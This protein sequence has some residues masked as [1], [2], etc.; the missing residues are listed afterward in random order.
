MEDILYV[1]YVQKSPA[2]FFFSKF[3][4]KLRTEYTA[5]N[6]RFVGKLCPHLLCKA[7]LPMLPDLWRKYAN[8]CN[9]VFILV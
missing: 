5:E 3:L 8:I 4:C 2:L 1:R 6:Q 9:F 7:G